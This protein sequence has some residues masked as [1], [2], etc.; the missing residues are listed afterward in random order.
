VLVPGLLGGCLCLRRTLRSRA[1]SALSLWLGVLPLGL[2]LVAALSLGEP[3]YRI[4]FDGVFMLFAAALYVRAAPGAVRWRRSAA[5]QHCLLAFAG[6]LALLALLVVAL[7]S[8]PK[9][10]LAARWSGVGSV[11]VD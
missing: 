3:R 6:G 10:R 4:P 9:T 2:C 8:H 7:V 5:G 11:R 1:R